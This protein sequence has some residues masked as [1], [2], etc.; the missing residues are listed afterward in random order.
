MYIKR[1]LGHKTHINSVIIQCF[2][3]LWPL[4]LCIGVTSIV[5][6]GR[7]NVKYCKYCHILGEIFCICDCVS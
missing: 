3:F 2:C 5:L 1:L 6:E 4:C 7:L